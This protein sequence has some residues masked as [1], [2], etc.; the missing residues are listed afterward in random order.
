MNKPQVRITISPVALS[1]A[2]K[3][4]IW[5]SDGSPSET[6]KLLADASKEAQAII[7]KLKQKAIDAK[8]G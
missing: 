3:V 2:Y 5:I 8:Q 6:Q 7:D 4:E 1:N